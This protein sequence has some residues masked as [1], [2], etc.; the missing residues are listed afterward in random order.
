M[1]A[2]LPAHFAG[3]GRPDY[4][5]LY[6]GG[7]TVSEVVS[8]YDPSMLLSALFYLLPTLFLLRKK[9]LAL[10]SAFWRLPRP[11]APAA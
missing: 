8:S 11:E 6:E 3:H 10:V 9:R 5:G 4:T 1:G 7:A 2:D